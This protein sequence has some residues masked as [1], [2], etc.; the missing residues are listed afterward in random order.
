LESTASK[1][2]G[3]GVRRNFDTAKLRLMEIDPVLHLRYMAWAT[4]LT[5]DAA[6]KLSAEEYAKDRGSSHAGIKTTLAHMFMADTLWF[7]RIAGEPYAK[8]SDIAIPSTLDE[9]EREWIQ[10]LG[11]WQKW[12]GQLMPN[13]FGIEVGYTNSEGIAYRTPLWQIV[14]HLVNHS[15]MHR[16]QVIAMMRQAGMTPPVTDLIVFYRSLEKQ[17]A[18]AG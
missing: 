18:P 13:Q 1:L 8:I 12:V 9:L 14:V 7:S 3:T 16:G 5:L 2:S 11:R 4:Q 15:T 6:K 17:A 10:L